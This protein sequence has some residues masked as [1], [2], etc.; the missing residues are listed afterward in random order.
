MYIILFIHSYISRYLGCFHLLAVVNTAA[1]NM[2]VQI[3]LRVPAFNSFGYI[4]RSV[5][6]LFNF[7]R[8]RHTVS[9]GSYTILHSYQQ[10]IGFQ[11][12]HILDNTCYF[13]IF[14][15]SYPNGCEWYLIVVLIYISLM[16][17]DV[18]H[19]FMC[20][21]ATVYLLEKRLFKSLPIFQL[22]GFVVVESYVYIFNPTNDMSG[23]VF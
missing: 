21:L 12:L 8:H 3:S 2:G 16:I 1:V 18:E 9:Q 4:P 20:L 23:V 13:L 11:F 7:L 22:S 14:N 17:S 15:S 6:I 5:V 19:L 10:C